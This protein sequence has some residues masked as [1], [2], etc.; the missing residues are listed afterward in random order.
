MIR[1]R[2]DLFFMTPKVPKNKAKGNNR[3]ANSSTDKLQDSGK[4]AGALP[5]KFCKKTK[6]KPTFSI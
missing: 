1:N 6:Y 5:K 2:F 3:Y 4:K